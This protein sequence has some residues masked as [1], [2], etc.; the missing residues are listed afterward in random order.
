M[1]ADHLP[2]TPASL[3][4]GRKTQAGAPPHR[5]PGRNRGGQ[6]GNQN[7]RKH[8]F[9]SGALDHAEIRELW[10]IITSEGVAPEMALLR[11]KLRSSLQRDPGNPRVLMH[12]SNLLAKWYSAKSGLNKTNSRRLKKVILGILKQYSDTC[13]PA[14]RQRRTISAKRIERTLT[15]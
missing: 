5:I 9:Y 10:N 3:E 15:T 8:G 2:L 4:Q 1:D 7:A 13:L 14:W 11:I 6:K 12:A